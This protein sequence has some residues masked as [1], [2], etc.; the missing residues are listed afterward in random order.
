MTLAPHDSTG[1]TVR[2]SERQWARGLRGGAVTPG[3]TLLGAVPSDGA[4]RQ[5]TGCGGAGMR[6]SL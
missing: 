5:A 2:K 6:A 3:P 1:H 4:T